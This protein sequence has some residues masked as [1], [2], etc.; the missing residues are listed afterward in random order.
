MVTW[1]VSW[2]RWNLLF[3]ECCRELSDQPCVC[4]HE[5]GVGSGQRGNDDSM[6]V[7]GFGLHGRRASQGLEGFAELGRHL[8]AR[9]L[10]GGRILVLVAGGGVRVDAGVFAGGLLDVFSFSEVVAEP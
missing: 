7:H 1:W 2:R 10:V 6:T 3:A 9:P 4:C 8:F 5:F